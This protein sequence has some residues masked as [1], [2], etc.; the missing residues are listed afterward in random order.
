MRSLILDS[1][2]KTACSV[3][4]DLGAIICRDLAS[5][6]DDW[7]FK[8]VQLT[9]FDQEVSE[10]IAIELEQTPDCCLGSMAAKIK[11]RVQTARRLLLDQAL[12]HGLR[13]W[14]W[15][16]RLCN[17]GCER[18][19]GLYRGASSLRYDLSRFLTAGFLAAIRQ[20][21]SAAGGAD[22]TKTTRR[23]LLALGV[24]IQAGKA[25]SAKSSRAKA[26]SRTGKCKFATWAAAQQK[27]M[28]FNATGAATGR[29]NQRQRR[30]PLE[31]LCTEGSLASWRFGMV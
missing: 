18:L 25:Q 3:R 12:L 5:V 10:R 24:S 20:R 15:T 1:V 11:R 7:P 28:R 16:R 8:L 14:S 22:V 23:Q 17:M 4:L 30:V 26:S 2:V 29:K 19:L 27:F 6:Y 13:A 9:M 21:H 31:V